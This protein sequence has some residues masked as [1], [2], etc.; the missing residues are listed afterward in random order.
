[1]SQQQ[2][3]TIEIP[4]WTFIKK[5]AKYFFAVFAVGLTVGFVEGRFSLL[6]SY[7]ATLFGGG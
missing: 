3:T 6:Q 7:V 2:Y 4:I 1:M 5:A